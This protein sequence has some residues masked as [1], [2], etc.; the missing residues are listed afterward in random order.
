MGVPP[1]IRTL[2]QPISRLSLAGWQAYAFAIAMIAL[3]LLLRWVLPQGLGVRVPFPTF[4]L[5]VFLSAWVGGWRA[6]LLASVLTVVCG[7][8]VVPVTRPPFDWRDL[9]ALG[10]VFSVCAVGAYAFA[11][12]RTSVDVIEKDRAWY[13]RILERVGDAVLV[14]DRHGC[15]RYFNGRAA[16]LW[17]LQERDLGRS[18]EDVAGFWL[19][20]SDRRLDDIRILV[21]EDDG[22]GELPPGLEVRAGGR[23]VPV[24]GNVSRFLDPEYGPALVVAVQSI[25]ALREAVRQV[26]STERRMRALSGAGIVGLFSINGRGRISTINPA[27]LRLLGYPEDGP[28][29]PETL[30]QIADED[31]LA[32]IGIG[33]S[34]NAVA[35]GPFDCR[36]L[37][38]GGSPVW[39]SLGV[40]PIS[41]HERMVF[42]TDIRD[43]KQAEREIAS[44]E[45]RF[46]QLAEA[47]AAVVWQ[48]CSSG[49]LKAQ[50]GWSA[51]TGGPELQRFDQWLDWIHPDD[52]DA[53]RGLVEALHTQHRGCEAEFRLRHVSGGYRHV[54]VRAVVLDGQGCGGTEWIGTLRDIHERRL[55]ESGLAAKQ[56]ELRL[57]LD[58]VPARIAYMDADGVF[59]WANG[60][61]AEWFEVDGDV[62]GRALEAVMP[63]D[64]VATLYQPLQ[65]ARRGFTSQIE[66]QER[67]AAQGLRWTTTTF[68]PDLDDNGRVRGVISLCMDSTERHENEE[69]LRRSDAE[70]RT[71]AENVPHMVWMSDAGGGLQYCNAR[72]IEY[73][74][75]DVDGHWTGP[76]HPDDRPA[77]DDAFAEASRSLAGLNVEARYMRASDGAFRWHLVRALP[78]LDD[79]GRVLRWYGTCTD[80]EDQKLAQDSL[81]EAHS[82]TTHFLATLSH[83]LRNPL[84]A[85]MASTEVLEHALPEAEGLRG[86]LQAIRRQSWHLKRLTDDLLDISRITLGRIQMTSTVIDLREICRDVCIDF[87]DKARQHDVVLDC[88]VPTHAIPVIGDPSRI[89]QCVDNLVSNAIKAS[90]PGMQVHVETRVAERF[91]EIRVRDEGV[92]VEKE[93]LSTL[94][95]PFSQGDAW[96][97]QGLGLGLS[98]VSKLVELHG[99]SVWVHSDG[100]NL[101]STFG[102]RLPLADAGPALS[103]PT[104]EAP[105]TELVGKVLIVEDETDNAVALQYLLALDGHEVFVA[106]DGIAGLTLAESVRPDVVIC[107]LG[108]PPPMNG[109][110]VARRLREMRGE[111]VYL[112]AYSGYGAR[113]DVQRSLEAGFDAHLTKPGTPRAIAGEVA[114]GLARVKRS[115][116]GKTLLPG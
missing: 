13:Q 75:R 111:D 108:L 69:A 66:W 82:R 57:I 6:G 45:A 110:E 97:N 109:L 79:A 38:R 12:L 76:M 28:E 70:H 63:R 96:R 89:R 100:R 92:G 74:G 72:W 90:A 21:R 56:I 60:R 14:V 32:V 50:I 23:A 61:F 9:V 33:G 95:L 10:F 5:A 4:F 104:V 22:S 26:E 71:L 30:A 101:G 7:M 113:E 58:A 94:F 3:A 83:E 85:L 73:T 24:V 41:S 103:S 39:V 2:G 116:E 87:S 46:R 25:H 42:V 93:S 11:R 55:A 16:M 62:K 98:I 64:V 67:P 107:D 29:R 106:E 8:T 115:R 65:V 59:Q 54:S 102:I 81:R 68:S 27:M 17:G 51:F 43:R 47:S 1:L 35:F 19:E 40:V 20:G 44:S 48:A 15:L 49:D 77:A 53:A 91:A 84:A 36:L 88:Q 52:L 114:R 31:L 86:T 105:V 18:A 78:L 34:E 99:G 80:I 37:E 112:C